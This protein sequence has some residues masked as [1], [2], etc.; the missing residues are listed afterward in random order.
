MYSGYFNHMGSLRIMTK[1]GTRRPVTQWEV[2]GNQGLLW[3]SMQI[4]LKLDSET[5]VSFFNLISYYLKFRSFVFIDWFIN[6]FYMQKTNHFKLI[7]YKII[8]LWSQVSKRGR[9]NIFLDFH[10]YLFENGEQKLKS[11]ARY[12]STSTSRESNCPLW[13]KSN[14][15]I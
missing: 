3:R 9:V 4:N 8:Y 2:S 1:T 11:Y 15:T 7:I 6:I 12:T 10:K 14:F 13:L 5:K